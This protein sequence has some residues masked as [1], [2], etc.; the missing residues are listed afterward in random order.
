M[1]HFVGELTVK[2]PVCQT[3]SGVTTLALTNQQATLLAACRFHIYQYELATEFGVL[4]ACMEPILFYP[5]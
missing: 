5:N 2:I 4:F 3:T 1:G